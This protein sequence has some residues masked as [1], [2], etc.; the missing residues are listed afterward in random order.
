MSSVPKVELLAGGTETGNRGR[1]RWFDVACAA[2]ALIVLSPLLGLIA[3]A[4]K[5][6]DGGPVFYSQSRTGKD[7]RVFQVHKFRSMVA[8]ADRNGLLTA[9]NDPRVTPIGRFLRRSKLDELPQLV[10]VLAGDMQLVGSRP[11]AAR[12]VEMFRAEYSVIL[13]ER[14]GITDPASLAFRHEERLLSSADTEE[15][16]VREIL[17]AKLKLSLAYQ[18]RRTFWSDIAVLLRTGIALIS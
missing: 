3:A 17:P 13:R 7:F 10:N 15:K 1:H 9:S 18:Q 8:G 12:Y 11:E 14:P 4:I 6:A 5:L 2:A 16:Y